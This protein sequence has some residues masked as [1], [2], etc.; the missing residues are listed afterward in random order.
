MKIVL[1][2]LS[3][4]ISSSLVAQTSFTLYIAAKNGLTIR[5]RPDI[6]SNTVDKIPYGEKVEISYD[7]NEVKEFVSEGLKG[8]WAKVTY[9][10]KSGYIADNYLLPEA[11]PKDNVSNLKQYLAQIS[12][13]VSEPIEV[14]T[15]DET[16]KEYTFLKKQLYKNGGEYHESISYTSTEIYFLPGFNIQK[17]FVLMRLL[18]EYKTA[19]NI[20][21]AFPAKNKT[22]KR[23]DIK[24]D[25]EVKKHQY[26]DGSAEI[27]KLIIYS[28]NEKEFD[29]TETFQIFEMPGSI[30]G[31]SQVVIMIERGV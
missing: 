6:T 28:F 1:L 18:S 3:I 20:S 31:L 2:F 8:Y 15:K 22:M 17:A 23:G 4:F 19:F 24:V 16:D 7:Y 27:E 26:E 30:K 5:E 12:S 21:D 14:K 25:T 29:G 10:G 9:N 13:P 11:P